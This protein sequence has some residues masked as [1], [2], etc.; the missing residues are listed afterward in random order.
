M[1][2]LGDRHGPVAEGTQQQEVRDAE[3]GHSTVLGDR[4]DSRDLAGAETEV[5][6]LCAC[7]AGKTGMA[8]NDAKSDCSVDEVGGAAEG[9]GQ[10][11]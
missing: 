8:A 3:E 10:W 6:S 9:E 1:R 11:G 4:T 7:A 5:E 2:R